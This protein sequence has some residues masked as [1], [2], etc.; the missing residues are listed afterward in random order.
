METTGISGDA[1]NFDRVNGYANRM[2]N[3][4]RYHKVNRQYKFIKFLIWGPGFDSSHTKLNIWK[5]FD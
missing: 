5:L 2:D 1:I 4:H 3:E